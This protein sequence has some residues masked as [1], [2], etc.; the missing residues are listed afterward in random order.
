MN[1]MVFS[2]EAMESGPPGLHYFIQWKNETHAEDTVESVQGIA[3][4]QHQIKKHHT[5]NPKNSAAISLFTYKAALQ[6]PMAT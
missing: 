3:Y 6:T 4:L 5:E 1:I 2:K